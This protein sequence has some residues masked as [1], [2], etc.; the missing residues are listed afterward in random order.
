MKVYAVIT[1]EIGDEDEGSSASS[2]E[3]AEDEV[4]VAQQVP[5]TSRSAGSSKISGSSSE[6]S[7]NDST[8]LHLRMKQL[9]IFVPCSFIVQV[10]HKN[11]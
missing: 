6:V 3:Q 2:S 8:I 7:D 5:S 10:E 9:N 11:L 4:T 1:A